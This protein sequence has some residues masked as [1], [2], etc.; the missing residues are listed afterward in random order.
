MS[1]VSVVKAE[2]TEVRRL[3]DAVRRYA[4]QMRE[5]VVAVRRDAAT[6]ERRTREVAEE[7]GRDV[8]V[9]RRLLDELQSRLRGAESGG[10]SDVSAEREVAEARAGLAR[11]EAELRRG[12]EAARLAAMVQSDLVQAVQRLDAVVG[13]TASVSSAALASLEAA[14]AEITGDGY[15]AKLQQGAT[16]LG[17]AARIT[18]AGTGSVQG[19]DAVSQGRIL[20]HHE[21]ASV[22][23]MR[24]RQQEHDLEL[25]VDGRD[26][27]M[28]HEAQGGRNDDDS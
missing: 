1:A 27:E 13:E 4:E 28:E 15:L 17:I 26:L 2:R 23:E 11:A 6:L 14:L 12:R 9:A 20:P 24:D 7:R 25:F 22:A 21:P 19:L 5:A 18:M 16:A 10:G 3:R 8:A